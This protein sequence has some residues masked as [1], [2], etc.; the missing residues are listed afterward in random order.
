M[1]YAL[2]ADSDPNSRAAVAAI[3]RSMVSSPVRVLTPAGPIDLRVEEEAYLVGPAEIIGEA[4][5]HWPSIRLQKSSQ[6]K[7]ELPVCS[8]VTSLSN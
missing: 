3:A 1:W 4:T 5:A 8:T 7:F 6:R 2:I